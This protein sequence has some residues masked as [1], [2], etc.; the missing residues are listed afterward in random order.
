VAIQLPLCAG[1]HERQLF[2]QP[3]GIAGRRDLADLRFRTAGSTSGQAQSSPAA[4]L[5]K[6]DSRELWRSGCERLLLNFFKS[7]LALID[8]WLET[9][10]SVLVSRSFLWADQG[11][12]LRPSSRFGIPH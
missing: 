9:P 5:R 7:N 3:G 4:F 10:R 6:R 1:R 12:R 8:P 2:D 11:A